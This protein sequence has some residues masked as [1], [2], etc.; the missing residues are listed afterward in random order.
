[1]SK[2]GKVGDER[3]CATMKCKKKEAET[4][5]TTKKRRENS[6]KKEKKMEENV[7]QHEKET[8]FRQDK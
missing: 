7:K 1:M 4:N 8:F 6:E 5:L 3:L 2:H